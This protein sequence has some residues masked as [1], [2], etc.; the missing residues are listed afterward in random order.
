[1]HDPGD[2]VPPFVPAQTTYEATAR[3]FSL[4][5]ADDPGTRGEKRAIVALRDALGLDV[6]VARTSAVMGRWVAD[7]LAV[8]WRPNYEH[9][10]TVNLAGLNALLSG[11]TEAFR[12]GSLRRLSRQRPTGLADPRWAAFEPAR[13]KIEAVNRISALTGSGPEWLGPG[14]K[15]HKRV[16][17]N[18]ASSLA[19]H[20][21]TRLSK[22][23]LGAA[24]SAEF[25]AP[26]TDD[27]MSTGETISLVGLNTLLAGA[28]LRLGRLG[29]ARAM[30]LGTPEEEGQALVA[31][32]VDAW[33]ATRHEDGARR[34][35]WDGRQCIRWMLNQGV[36]N[37]PNQ[38][39]WQG[40]YWEARGRAILNAAFTANPRPP[41]LVYGNTTF[42]YSLRF[43]WDL[44]AHTEAWRYPVS[45]TTKRGQ[46][47]APLNDQE[48][49]RECVAEQGLGFL[50]VGGVAV[51]D[52][53]GSF[54]EW[55]RKFKLANGVKKKAANSDKSR[56]RKTAFEPRHVEAFYFH[57]SL[58][59]KAA[60]AAGHVTGFKQG[61]QPPGA[62]G[63]PGKPRHP[64]YKLNVPKAR[65][66]GL[67]CARLDWPAR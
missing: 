41:Q 18:L 53:D 1:M 16:L 3:I 43:A 30:L 48:A 21:D 28:E 55:H 13:S 52:E 5:G 51:A 22:T 17:I 14:S 27:C 23:R 64:K 15:E 67:A 9:R 8:D 40:F 19:P 20:L 25:G 58:E 33:R 6:D 60:T 65:S 54:V 44:K 12:R 29:V 61:K 39:E 24:L 32:L 11:A 47:S 34:V 62:K 49:I 45:G 56:V 26:W 50:V 4:T 42:D 59:L 7:A 63:G 66:S 46:A 37:G 31:A 2:A 36:V 35:V 38:N 10:N 57:N